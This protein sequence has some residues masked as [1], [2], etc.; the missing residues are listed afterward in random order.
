MIIDCDP[1]VDDAHALF[2]AIGARQRLGL[3][4]VTVVAGN[5]GLGFTRANALRIRDATGLDAAALPIHAGCPAPLTGG[6]TDAADIHGQDGLD[7]AGLPPSR[8]DV[9]PAHAVTFLIERLR[10]AAAQGRPV[11]LVTLGP[12]TNLAAALI[13]AP[14]IVDGLLEVR[15]MVGSAAR[16]N[17][18][19]AAEFNAFVDPEAL[20]RVAAA[21]DVPDDV[22][23]RLHVYG[24]THPH[25]LRR[26]GRNRALCGT[27][28]RAG[29]GDRRHA[30]RLSVASSHTA[31]AGDG[32]RPGRCG[33]L[34]DPC[35]IGHLLAPDAVAG[36]DGRMTVVLRGPAR[37]QT[38]ASFGDGA[39]AAGR[40]RDVRVRWMV[41]GDAAALMAAL[42]D[43]VA[44][45]DPV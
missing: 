12:L 44:D 41:D 45:C 4:A 3:E 7:G 19:S 14:D 30:G 18:T 35:V 23:P 33:T 31:A 29:P 24:L 38:L 26:C 10:R 1:G 39:P 13:L 43:A 22:A 6:T 5:V 15:A 16:G 9:E 34:H 40:A 36:V 25:G 37:G 20:D 8:G 28:H 11:R 21:L 17:I 27:R 2:A 32:W 42:R